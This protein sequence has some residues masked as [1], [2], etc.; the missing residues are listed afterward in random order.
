MRWRNF[1]PIAREFMLHVDID[2]IAQEEFPATNVPGN[3]GMS[4]DEVRAALTEFT[5]KRTC[6]DWTLRN[7]ILTKMRTEPGP[8][9]W[10]N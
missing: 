9:N 8:V 4:F 6:W 7:T 3:G 1:M 10:L 5:K 2:V